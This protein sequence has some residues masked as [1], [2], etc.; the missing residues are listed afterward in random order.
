LPKTAG[1][2]AADRSTNQLSVVMQLLESRRQRVAL[3]GAPAPLFGERYCIAAV[4]FRR[5]G[6][7]E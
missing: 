2:P 6:L 4:F 7:L 1:K 5:R 3:P